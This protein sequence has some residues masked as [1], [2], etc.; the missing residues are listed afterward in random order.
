MNRNQTREWCVCLFVSMYVSVCG[1]IK[2]SSCRACFDVIRQVTDYLQV[3][4]LPPFHTAATYKD[5]DEY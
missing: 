5:E 2:F 4:L 3:L 1:T